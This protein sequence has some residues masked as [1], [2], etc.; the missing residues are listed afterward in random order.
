M[1]YQHVSFQSNWDITGKEVSSFV[2]NILN[3]AG[4]LEGVND[5]YIIM[6]P[7]I[8]NP[9]K[10]SDYKLISLCNVIYKVVAKVLSNLLKI[11]LPDIIS[12]NQSAFVPCRAITDNIM[13]AYETLHSMSTRIQ[14]RPAYIALKLNMSK[15]Y[16]RVEWDFLSA[17]MCKM[18]FDNCTSDELHQVYFIFNPS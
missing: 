12:V 3:N 18:G 14:G 1:V 10:V 6:I 9:T 11:M 2:L 5:T 7:K 15:A 8:K 16:D 13:V 4:S 17:V